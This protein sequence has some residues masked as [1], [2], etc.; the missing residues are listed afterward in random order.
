MN[1][2][3]YTYIHTHTH[4]RYLRLDLDNDFI[5]PPPSILG[6]VHVSSGNLL[7]DLV[8]GSRPWVLE[9]LEGRKEGGREGGNNNRTIG[10]LAIK[11]IVTEY[12]YLQSS[13]LPLP[14]GYSPARNLRL[15]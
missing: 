4:T 12:L 1:A 6:V 8:Q 9:V 2:L 3:T 5:S 10:E 11:T 14:L 15:T 7:C 13:C